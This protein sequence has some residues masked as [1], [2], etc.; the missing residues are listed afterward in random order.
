MKS[1]F[2]FI[3]FVV[4]STG[5]SAQTMKGLLG[6]AKDLVSAGNNQPGSQEIVS[7]LKE[8]LSIGAEKGTALLSREDG[9]FKNALLKIVLP[10]EVQKVEKT[11]RSIGMAKQVDEAILTMNRGAEEACKQAAPIF[12]DA[13]RSMDVNDAIGI[14][15]GGDT[16]AT[17]FLRKAVTPSL[18]ES[19]RPVIDGSLKKMDATKY[20]SA[21][22][23]AYNKISL[24][25]IN[26]DLTAYVT[27]KAIHGVFVQIAEEEKEIRKNPAARTTDLL[28]KVFQ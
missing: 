24:R 10:P 28:K 22:V 23:S 6:S 8:A 11:L 20:W 3:V 14:L 25:K 5:I 17:S 18:T 19:F 9:F 26:P 1:L 2:S 12:V 16:A 4:F 13:I 27:E 7:G 15:K 21:I